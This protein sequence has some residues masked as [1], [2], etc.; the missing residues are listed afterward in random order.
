[1]A[2]RGDFDLLPE[3]MQA[4]VSISLGA[5]FKGLEMMTSPQQSAAKIFDQAQELLTVPEY[6]GD[7]LADKA[8]AVAAV[9]VQK[10]FEIVETCR[11]AG[12]KF[13]EPKKD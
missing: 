6:A 10:S 7:G 1:M 2:R 9:W 11:E 8:Q 5:C 13:T 4:G 12:E 3:L